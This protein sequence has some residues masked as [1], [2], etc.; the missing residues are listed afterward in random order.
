MDSEHTTDSC[1]QGIR[2]LADSDVE[3]NQEEIGSMEIVSGKG[4]ANADLSVWAEGYKTVGF[5]G[6]HLHQAIEELK[7]MRKNKSKIFLGYTSNLISSGVRDIIAYLV[8]NRYVDVV[9]TTAG[10]IEED[11][12]KTMKPSRLGVFSMDGATLRS[13]GLNRVGN[14]LIPN[15]NYFVFEEWM[16]E[17]LNE[18]VDDKLEDT[19]NDEIQGIGSGY[20][21]VG[22]ISIITPSRFIYELGRKVNSEDSVYYWAHKNNIPVYCPA[23]TDGSIGDIITYFSR[24]RELVI[25][26]VEDIARINGEGLFCES[27]GALILGAGVIK[28]HILNANLFRNGLDHCVL[29][30][31]AQEYDGSDA[32]AQVDEAVSWGK[33]K[34]HTRSVKVHADATI[35]LPI[36]VGAVWPSPNNQQIDKK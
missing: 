5:Q 31:T 32:G 13:H 20:R 11:I 36:I 16:K 18:I 14:V 10:G 17:F 34:K 23:I 1:A 21:R 9:V 12:I 30:N 2:Q 26:T 6:S 24:R 25:D 27:T 22:N 7:I 28:H 29:V 35:V 4:F 15:E 19:N 3:E 8:K 33:I